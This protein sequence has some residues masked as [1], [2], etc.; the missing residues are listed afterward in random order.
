MTETPAAD[1]TGT[2]PDTLTQR[3]GVLA[4]RETEARVLVPVIEA[5]ADAFG[6]D[7]VIGIVRDTIIRIAREQGG[8]LAT[9]MGD[10]GPDAFLDS[11]KYW[12]QDNALEIDV[13]AHEPAA[14]RCRTLRVQRGALPLCRDVPRPWHSGTRR[15]AVLQSGLRADGGL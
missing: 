2:L 1:A 5:L 9:H 3:I 15:P 12:R 13:V 6:R 11:M 7:A 14:R 10:N 8:E 4:R